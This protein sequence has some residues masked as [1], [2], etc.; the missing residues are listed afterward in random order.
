MS[1]KLTQE[2]IMG[3]ANSKSIESIKTLNLWGLKLSDISILSELPLLETLSLS[4]NQIKDISV[5]KQM[6]NIKELYLA[7]NQIADINQIENLK[8]CKKLEKLVLKGNPINNNPNYIKKILEILPNL[9][10]IDEKDTKSLKNEK[11]DLPFKKNKAQKINGNTKQIYKN[12][13]PGI[14]KSDTKNENKG[15]MAAPE[16]GSINNINI[17][18]N[19][20]NQNQNQNTKENENGNE[21]I[22]NLNNINNN[23]GIVDPEVGDPKISEKTLEIFNKSFKKKKTEGIFKL[24]R[25]NKNANPLNANI[26]RN[27][28]ELSLNENN[29]ELTSSRNDDDDRFKTL[30]TSL[31]LRIFS[32]DLGQNLKRNG[33]K[34]KI[35]GNYKNDS[36]KLNQSTYIK[37][38]Q[39][40][41]EEEEEEKRKEDSKETNLNRSFYLKFNAQ[42]YN[43]KIADKKEN[44]FMINSNNAK[45]NKNNEKVE[46]EKID[47][48]NKE[49]KEK[50]M[51][52]I[53]LL[54]GTLSVDGLKEVQN[55]IQNLLSN[56]KK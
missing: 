18:Q 37:Y 35:I 17:N 31:S 32:N 36:S 1:K 54:I 3:R 5:F 9:T 8:N 16:P 28:N 34:R 50:I 55:E 49:K 11:N 10:I 47:N 24:K 53:Q 40:D 48:E 41:N 44:S 25:N 42:T 26:G 46:N 19:N 51:K 6:K 13:S 56:I 12:K 14:K 23:C 33:Y 22:N 43:K 4:N 30:Q 20:E 29:K 7:D 38:K 52:S 45:N 39:F 2:D 27:L 15:N 21:N